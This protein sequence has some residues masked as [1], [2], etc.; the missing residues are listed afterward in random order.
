[1]SWFWL[2]I[3]LAAVF[4][5]ATAGIPMWLVLRHPDTG[6]SRWPD[7]S[8][9]GDATPQTRPAIIVSATGRRAPRELVDA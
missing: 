3:P 6:A 2:N 9:I 8:R 5:L 4:F 7:P 1:M